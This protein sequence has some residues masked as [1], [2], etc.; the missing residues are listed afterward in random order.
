MLWKAR[1]GDEPYWESPFGKGRPGWH[2][3]CSA[4][5]MKYLKHSF[6]LHTGGVDNIFP[7][8]ENEIAQSEGA[9]GQ[10]FVRYWIHVA[11]L[12]VDAEKMAKSK[13]NFYTLRDLL[14]QGHDPRPIRL[15]LL[16][17]HYRTPL[18]FTFDALSQ[19]T[20]EVQRLDDLAARLDRE[21][22][23]PGSNDAFDAKV[24]EEAGRFTDALADDL[25]I[26][27]A[28]GALFRLVREAHVA[29]DRGELPAG[30]RNGLR[31]ALARFDE[32]L[33]VLEGGEQALDAE[34]DDAIRRRAEARKAKDFA[35]ADRIRDELAARGI[36]LEDTPQGTVWK[37]QLSAGGTGSGND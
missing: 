13:G 25:N 30:S 3:E 9:T 15:L 36:I 1:R 18:N 22:E 34:V 7:H 28:L 10:P 35:E 5:S 17:T 14:E 12:M 26:S 37:R 24:S 19:S 2:L 23:A 32:V 21:P 16:G 27:S 4:M 6:D 29:M 8:H 11:H 31:R 20:C 33:G